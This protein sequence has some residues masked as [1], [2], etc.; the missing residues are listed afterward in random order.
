MKNILEHI[1]TEL[2]VKHTGLYARKLYNEHPFKDKLKGISKMLEDYNIAGQIEEIFDKNINMLKV[3]FVV[4]IGGGNVL[5]Q[6]FANGEAKILWNQGE[7]R[8]SLKDFLQLWD[9]K[10]IFPKSSE[11]SVEPGYKENLKNQLYHTGRKYLL[12]MVAGIL[13][14]SGFIFNKVLVYTGCMILLIIN[15]IGVYIGYLLVQKQMHIRNDRADKICSIFK[16]GGCN[17]ILESSAS[18]LF[19][20]I[21]WSEVGL[22]YFIS[23]ILIV[24]L[25]PRLLPYLAL[26]NVFVLPYSF[27]SVWYQK[28][29]AKQWCALCLIVQVLLWM[30]FLAN[31][32]FAYIS[33]P[34]FG[35]I[36]MMLTIMVYLVPF[37]VIS[38]LLPILN[39][40]EQL[41]LL[42]GI[43]NKVKAKPE[44]FVTSL[45]HQPR[46]EVDDSV[47]RIVW[48]N[49]DGGL[50]VT[51]VTN[52]YCGYCAQM[53]DR[54]EKLFKKIGDKISVR[55]VFSFD[56]NTE[57]GSKYL[58]AVYL[59]ER[60]TI[61]QKKKV[62]D[63]WF[64]NPQK[65][66]DNLIKKYIGDTD[67]ESVNIEME[68]HKQWCE[69]T[70]N[71][72]TPTILVDGYK[73]PDDYAIEDIVWLLDIKK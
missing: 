24:T 40:G 5:V 42:M 50:K 43:L 38:L 28:F 33:V 27:W 47:S 36:D 1:L 52:P 63:D 62:F 71:Y 67:H 73:L 56:K 49:R 10:V 22:S 23:N 66:N 69:K 72:A 21:G 30:V 51:V 17:G 25:F 45:I 9:G 18:K 19:G 44:V 35:I 3:P 61:L 16:K 12:Y 55:Y 32:L 54:I 48:G 68:N 4:H 41:Q 60:L 46:Y 53:H 57:E 26:I 29:K 8:I 20:I 37:L 15:M 13:L 59:D 6:E 64:R 65:R 39:S 11:K 14:I 7:V 70:K 58:M 34:S 31:I 2:R